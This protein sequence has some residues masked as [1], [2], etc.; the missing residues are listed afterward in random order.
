[1]I[2]GVQ[3]KL[4]VSF[5]EDGNMQLDPLQAELLGLVDN[6]FKYFTTQYILLSKFKC[7]NSVILTVFAIKQI[8]HWSETAF[9]INIALHKI[10]TYK[11]LAI[12]SYP[13]N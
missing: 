9:A 6:E 10:A 1:M 11:Q 12:F 2:T 3:P 5:D 8:K 7:M 13:C 4:L